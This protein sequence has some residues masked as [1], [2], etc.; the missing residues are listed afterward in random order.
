MTD[1]KY[2]VYYLSI[3]AFATAF[4]IFP[5]TVTTLA[6]EFQVAPE[7]LD[8][9]SSTISGGFFLAMIFC[10]CLSERIGKDRLVWAG[11]VFLFLALFSATQ[12]VRLPLLAVPALFL[13]FGAGLIEISATALISEMTEEHRRLRVMNF[14]QVMF[15]GGVVFGPLVIGLLLQSGVS[16]RGVFHLVGLFAL[17]PCFFFFGK[18]KKRVSPSSGSIGFSGVRR[19]MLQSVFVLLVVQMFLYVCAESGYANW[20]CAHFEKTL[21][22]PVLLSSMMLSI[23][24]TGIGSGRLLLSLWTPPWSE[25]RTLMVF[26]GIAFLGTIPVLLLSRVPVV[27]TA[28]FL[29]GFGFSITWPTI[30]AL[31]GKC[32]PDHSGPAFSICIG[33]GGLGALCGAPLVGRVTAWTGSFRLGLLTTSLLICLS[34]I[35]FWKPRAARKLG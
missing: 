20:I 29:V 26:Y 11:L 24:W 19:L 35:L 1:R 2:L 6:R 5:T 13:G 31:V 7:R 4:S 30:V 32:C 21:G 34:L 28:V 14:S 12:V 15:C 3:L 10:T 22:A 18:L 9:L 16:W 17:L 23:Y 8:W 33:A 27:A 25:R